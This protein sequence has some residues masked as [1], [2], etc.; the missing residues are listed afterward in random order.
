[1]KFS[2]LVVASDEVLEDLE[3]C[4]SLFWRELVIEDIIGLNCLSTSAEDLN[5]NSVSLGSDNIFETMR[6]S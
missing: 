3:C 5:R 2:G 6:I 1:M 4:E